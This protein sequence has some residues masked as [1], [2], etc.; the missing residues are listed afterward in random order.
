M[1]TTNTPGPLSLARVA[2]AAWG[3]VVAARAEWAAEGET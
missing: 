3:V 2:L 1:S